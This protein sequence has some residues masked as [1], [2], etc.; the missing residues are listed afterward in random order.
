MAN[1]P[2]QT[3]HAASLEAL[4]AVA[5]N[6]QNAGNYDEAERLAK[7]VLATLQSPAGDGDPFVKGSKI[8]KAPSQSKI[9][10]SGSEALK[11]E[12]SAQAD[13]G[14]LRAHATRLLGVIALLRGQVHHCTRTPHSRT[15][16]KRS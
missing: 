12:M 6:A 13:E 4:L 1:D 10:R 15:E 2:V 5:E 7:E 8:E 14:D 9:L 3:Q 11:G 16:H